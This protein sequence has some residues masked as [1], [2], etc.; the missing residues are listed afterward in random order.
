MAEFTR[1]PDTGIDPGIDIWSSHAIAVPVLIEG[2]AHAA[3]GS[4][5]KLDSHIRT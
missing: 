3:V 4:S 5:A 1:E 2:E